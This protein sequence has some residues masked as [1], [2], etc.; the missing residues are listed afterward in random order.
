MFGAI[1]VIVF[2]AVL[3]VFDIIPLGRRQRPPFITITVWSFE[4]SRL[5]QG[6]SA[7]YTAAFPNIK[8]AYVKKNPETYEQELLNAL[9][10]GKGPDIFALSNTQIVKHKDKL[11]LLPQDTLLFRP[12][13]FRNTFL[14]QPGKI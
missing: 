8:I 7:R 11:S 12:R 5:W 4:E 6:A 1:G 14:R 10:S 9:A 3:V 13:D 2:L